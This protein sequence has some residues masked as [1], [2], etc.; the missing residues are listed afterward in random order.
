MS[1][2]NYRVQIILNLLDGAEEKY[3]DGA[4]NSSDDRER[5]DAH[6]QLYAALREIEWY[7]RDQN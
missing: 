4:I 3:S 2:Y 6:A 1:E 5:R 7:Y